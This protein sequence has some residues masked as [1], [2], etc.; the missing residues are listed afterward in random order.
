V[1][2]PGVQVRSFSEVDGSI[3]MH[4]VDVGRRAVVRNAIVDK[5]VRIPPGGQIGVDEAADRARG[6]VVEDGLTVL[7]KDQPFPA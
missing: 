2:S 1:L 5:N 3:L 4:G 6:F 7:G